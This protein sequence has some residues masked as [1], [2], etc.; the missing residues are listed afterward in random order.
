MTIN[1]CAAG[2][3]VRRSHS[4][5]T[6]TGVAGIGYAL[7][8]IAGLAIPAPNP[9]LGA[10]GTA[11][12]GA[13][14]GHQASAAVNFA[15]TEGL[16]A[17]GIAVVTLALAR[18][19]GGPL[20]RVLRAAGLTAT[21]ISV[22][23]FVLGLIVTRTRDAGA[24]HLLWASIDRIDGVKMLA[25]AVLGVAAYLATATSYRA[26][27]LP[28][29][30]RYCAAALAVTMTVSGLV[31]LMLAQALVIAAGPALLF[32]LVVITGAGIV[33]GSRAR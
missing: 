31:Y 28:R 12:L 6:V 23:E 8:W 2:T 13:Y 4:L 17:I 5:V 18:A 11:I 29:W 25:F 33:L 24:A 20:G 9:A 3:S 21:A 7:S 15:L 30:L 32:L 10:S 16:P 27:V 22:A 1:Q 14:A 19:T 26:A